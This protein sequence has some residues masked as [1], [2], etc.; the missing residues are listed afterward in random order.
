M[1]VVRMEATASGIS[2]DPMDLAEAHQG[3]VATVVEIWW[4]DLPEDVRHCEVTVL[5]F[6]R[7]SQVL[8]FLTGGNPEMTFSARAWRSRR[9]SRFLPVRIG[10]TMTSAAVDVVCAML[11]GEERHCAAAWGNYV[12]RAGRVTRL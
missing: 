9:T 10:W 5:A 12:R 6:F 7:A 8:N 2:A 1:A 4:S 11:R 3:V